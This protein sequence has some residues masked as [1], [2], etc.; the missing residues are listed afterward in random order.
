MTHSTHNTST[1]T[2]NDSNHHHKDSNSSTRMVLHYDAAANEQ[3]HH[4]PTRQAPGAAL[5]RMAAW[6]A[7]LHWRLA[8]EAN[9]RGSDT[10]NNFS[11]A[12]SSYYHRTE[13]YQHRSSR[14]GVQWRRPYEDEE[15]DEA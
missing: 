4:G 9:G 15:E 7:L 13:T 8:G 3:T 6:C 14:G 5:T 1:T 2:K 12:S 10:A 11:A